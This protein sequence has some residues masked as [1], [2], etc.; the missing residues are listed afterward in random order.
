MRAARFFPIPA[1]SL[2]RDAMY[3]VIVAGLYGLSTGLFVGRAARLWRL[4]AEQHGVGFNLQR[5]PW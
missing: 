5:D 3:T 4:A 1:P 2:T